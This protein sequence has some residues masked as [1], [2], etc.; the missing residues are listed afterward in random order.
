M[1]IY[2][3]P[4][5]DHWFPDPTSIPPEERSP[6]GLYAVGGDLHVERLIEAY[7]QGIFPWSAITNDELHWYCPMDRFVIFPEEIH[8]SHSMRT[9]LNKEKY[10]TSMDLDFNGVIRNCGKLRIHEEGAWLGDDIIKA[11]TELHRK[12][13]AHSVEVWNLEGKL[14]GGLYGI[15][16]NKSFIGESMFSLEPST[17]KIAL[18]S[19]AQS[20]AMNNFHMIDCQVETP[21]LKSMGGRH[22][23]YEEYMDILYKQ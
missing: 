18:I 15:M 22:I 20:M 7:S 16:M 6:E 8:I 3:L 2:K 11:Y 14:V 10:A 21:H 9:L 13:Y 1:T 5:D 23:S 4:E 12:G 17:S 19:L